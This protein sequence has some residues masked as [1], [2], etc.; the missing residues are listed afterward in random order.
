MSVALAIFAS[1]QVLAESFERGQELYENQCGEC[2]NKL[3][4]LNKNNKIKTLSE[5]RERITNWA[6]HTGSEWGDSEID[7]VLY[8][9]NMSIYHFTEKKL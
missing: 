2:H 9:L 3:T 4:T 5:L 1:G 6:T 7:D 8:Y